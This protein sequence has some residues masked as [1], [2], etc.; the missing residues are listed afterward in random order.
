M[1]AG[2]YAAPAVGMWHASAGTLAPALAGT[3]ITSLCAGTML[4]PS[5]K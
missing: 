2:F 4:P 5:V 3:T 1:T